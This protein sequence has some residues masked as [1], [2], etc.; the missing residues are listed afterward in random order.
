VGT[1]CTNHVTP[2]YPQKLALTSPTGGGRSVGMVRSRTEATECYIVCHSSLLFCS[3]CGL[4]IESGYGITISDAYF[5]TNIDHVYLNMIP[6]L[7]ASSPLHN[8][9]YPQIQGVCVCV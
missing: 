6:N 3:A 8:L 5:V 7:C 4:S 1:R 9:L 2:L